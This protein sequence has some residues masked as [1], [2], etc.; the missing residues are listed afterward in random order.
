MEFAIKKLSKSK[1]IELYASLEN[2][3]TAHNIKNVEKAFCCKIDEIETKW[4]NWAAK[5]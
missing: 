5:M 2:G 1:F 3:N 4:L